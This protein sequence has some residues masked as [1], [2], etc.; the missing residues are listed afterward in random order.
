VLICFLN[1]KEEYE[2]EGRNFC[3]PFTDTK[4]G[5]GGGGGKLRITFSL[6]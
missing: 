5:E 1:K 6:K 3:C 2:N 4:I